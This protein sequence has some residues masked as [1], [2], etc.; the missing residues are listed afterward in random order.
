VGGHRDGFAELQKAYAGFD[1]AG[2]AECHLAL[3]DKLSKLVGSLEGISLLASNPSGS[4]ARDAVAELTHLA[5]ES[6][7][8]CVGPDLSNNSETTLT[9]QRVVAETRAAVVIPSASSEQL[10]DEAGEWS[11]KENLLFF[12][13]QKQLFR[14]ATKLAADTTIPLNITN[15]SLL[16][17]AKATSAQY[18][19]TLVVITKDA[20][21]YAV[22]G[23]AA[24]S[25]IVIS[26]GDYGALTGL[27]GLFWLQNS[28]NTFE[29]LQA[30]MHIAEKAKL[31]QSFQAGIKEELAKL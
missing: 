14:L 30:A 13:N 1:A 2:A 5:D 22:N 27:I 26:S 21:I 23:K 15:E 9:M 4:I 3:P 10:M 11:K 31:H 25:K 6:D 20:V 7:V 16:E 19:P 29:A 12:V 18:A 8:V 24:L 28:G 17:I